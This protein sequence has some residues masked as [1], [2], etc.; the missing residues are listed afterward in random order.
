MLF[1]NEEHEPK[2][3]N[4]EERGAVRTM[5]E[6]DTREH[7]EPFQRDSVSYQCL[8]QILNNPSMDGEFSHVHPAMQVIKEVSPKLFL[9]NLKGKKGKEKKNLFCM[10][11]KS[12]S[13]I[14]FFFFF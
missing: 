7:L 12:L 3:E 9:K 4:K 14:F 2:S 10:E 6:E 13:L 8:S 11:N 5:E 1:T